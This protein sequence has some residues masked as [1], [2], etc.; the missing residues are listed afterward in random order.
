[1][2]NSKK[3]R[4]TVVEKSP[5]HASLLFVSFRLRQSPDGSDTWRVLDIYPQ[6][7][8]FG[9]AAHILR[10]HIL[11]CFFNIEVSCFS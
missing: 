5:N 3:E 8:I 10:G 4:V 1:M 7:I 6:I 9:D 2:S 11:I